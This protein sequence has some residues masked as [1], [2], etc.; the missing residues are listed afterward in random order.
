[1]TRN[2]YA[3]L[4]GI[5]DYAPESGVATLRGCVRDIQTAQTYLT[6]RIPADQLHL[7]ALFNEQATRQAIVD[8]FR[9]H[10]C[11]TES[12]DT[13]LFYYAGHGSQ[14]DAPEFFW[15]IEPDRMNETLVCYDSRVQGQF[16]L[17]DK[18]L[19]VLLGEVAQKQ[20]HIVLI[21]DCCHS[22]SGSRDP[23]LNA[24]E[25]RVP[26]FD[27]PRPLESYLFSANDIAS[28]A[29][30]SRSPQQNPAGWSLPQGRHVLLAAC[31]DHQTAEE[32]P[33]E[34]ERRGLFSYFL[35]KALT[36]ANGSLSYRDLFQQ[37]NALVRGNAIAQ[38]PQLEA[39]VSADLDLPFLGTGAIAPREPYFT[40]SHDRALGWVINGGAV[41]GI[42]PPLGGET[43][44]LKLFSFTPTQVLTEG[45][46]AEAIGLATVTK[47]HPQLSQISLEGQEAIARQMVFKAVV[48]SQPLPPMGVFLAAA[49]A[50]NES[51]INLVRQALSG[52]ITGRTSLYVA[53]VTEP[54]RAAFR[55]LAKGGE[56]W[57]TRS[58]DDRPLIAQLRGY[59]S[60]K[61]VE[62]VRNLEHIARWLK[63][64]ELQSPSSSRIPPDA[65]KIQIIQGE[66]E[67]ASEITE[68][69]IR[70]EYAYNATTQKWEEPTFRVKMTNQSAETLYC[71]LFDLTEQF[72][73]DATVLQGG[74]VRLLPHETVWVNGGQPIAAIVP[75][76]LWQQGVT[77][78]KDILKAIACTTDFDAMM[79]AQDEL[80]QP[81]ITDRSATR[82]SG[83]L[84]HLMQRIMTRKLSTQREEVYDDWIAS[85]VTL[86]IVRPQAAAVVSR[87]AIALLGM[88]VAIQPHPA[89]NAKARLTTTS[90]STRD[91]GHHMVPP[92]LQSTAT[93]QPFL[94]SASRGS[95][96]G[97]S[98]LELMD[99]DEAT[100]QSVT[101]EQPLMLT[102][103]GESLQA[104]EQLLAIAY[105]GEF[106][107][108]VGFGRNGD[109]QLE[110]N[111][112]RLPEPVGEGERSV[113]GSIRIFFQKVISQHLSLEFAYPL[114]AVADVASDETITYEIAEHQV[115]ARVAQAQRIVLYVHG[116]IGDT[117]SIVPS[118]R[119]AQIEVNGDRLPLCDPSLYDLVLAFDYEN[120]NT[121]IE[122]NARALKQRLEAIGLGAN[123]GKTLHIIAHSMGGLLSRWM[124]EREGGHQIV[125][126]LIMLGTPNAGSPWSNVQELVTPL[127]AIG[128][129]SLSTVAWP[130]AVIGNLMHLASLGVAGIEKI[131]VSLDQM[132]PRSDFLKALSESPDP[133]IPYTILAGNT[134]IIQPKTSEGLHKIQNFLN[135]LGR[136][137]IEFPFLGQPNDIAAT[138]NSITQIPTSNEKVDIHEIACDHL[139][140]FNHPVGLTALATAVRQA[141]PSTPPP[142]P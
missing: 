10:L 13:V 9:T 34:D 51:G 104:G 40:V 113:Q 92:I 53:A 27:R 52:T 41:H 120:L 117:E 71:A 111:L 16:D 116:I 67:S 121:S 64:V 123:H 93:G 125:N 42:A 54:D 43:T 72:E 98:V 137:A 141:L 133:G 18:E 25:R 74:T 100:R 108:P 124:I 57:V 127:L 33:I 139:T 28:F 112:D 107:L 36:Q 85:Q 11:Q 60:A 75:K 94:F 59:T 129:N 97:L 61:A 91:L 135:K 56:Y 90:Q 84:N 20:P 48:V 78:C 134:S 88:G 136:S 49:T 2:I 76:A 6:D 130:I 37:T 30:V 73:V 58:T 31:R 87:D 50:D 109:R 65:L 62:T 70:M 105:D 142:T 63:V 122:D 26:K 106:Y 7:I 99:V 8:A 83:S 140:Y 55:V 79:L 126:H 29:S 89:F 132:K 12:D 81:L 110:I 82:G 15:T 115:K 19:A 35:M 66:G 68:P 17:A 69:Q 4:V 138:V 23:L 1:M 5:N 102:V 128:L 80:G 14:E 101:P 22:G 86:T 47:V 38:S 119:R 24:K 95:D 44:T 46:Q 45:E 39:T 96:P 103:A 3:L 21:L 32:A 131:D 118:V 77:E 114:L